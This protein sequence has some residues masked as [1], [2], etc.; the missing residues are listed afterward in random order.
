MNPDHRIFVAGHRGMVGSALVRKLQEKGY[1]NLLLRT[2]DELDL[3]DQRATREFF[4][5]ER[6][7]QVFL[8]AARVGGLE[9]NNTYPA[10]FIRENLA[11]LG[12]FV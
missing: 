10:D 2:R 1:H 6:P 4:C 5:T 11:I 7:E 9:A 3:T 12:Q 8:A